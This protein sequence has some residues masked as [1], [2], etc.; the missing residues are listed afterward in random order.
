MQSWPASPSISCA[1]HS[2]TT[3]ILDVVVVV[4]VV[5]EDLYVLHTVA[6]RTPSNDRSDPSP[7]SLASECWPPGA[8][9]YPRIVAPPL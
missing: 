5:E 1:K 9:L 8:P 7:L 3:K 6:S 4:V 2:A